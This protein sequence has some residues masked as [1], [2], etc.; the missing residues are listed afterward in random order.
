LGNERSWSQIHLDR[1]RSANPSKIHDGSW[2]GGKKDKE[3]CNK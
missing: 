3:E 1:A 2:A